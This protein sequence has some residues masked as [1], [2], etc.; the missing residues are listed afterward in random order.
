MEDGQ[1]SDNVGPSLYAKA[2]G[3]PVK[4]WGFFGNGRLDY[5]VL[6]R[7]GKK[8][9]NMNGDTYEWLATERFAAWRRACFDDDSAVRLV[10]D[11]ERCLW[12]D[13][14]GHLPSATPGPGHPPPARLISHAPAQ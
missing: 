13:M 8:T 4:I 11:H 14:I 9:T 10:Q 12:Q 5:Y 3:L 7:D 6:P 1:W 2:Q